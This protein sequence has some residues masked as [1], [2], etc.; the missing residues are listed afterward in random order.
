MLINLIYQNAFTN[1]AA[2]YT[3]HMAKKKNL[4]LA[5]LSCFEKKNML[6]RNN[7]NFDHLL[8]LLAWPNG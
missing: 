5:E 2:I 6:I 8:N 3:Y 7:T 4:K 1:F